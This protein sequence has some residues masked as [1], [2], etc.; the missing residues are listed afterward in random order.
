MILDKD[1]YFMRKA[2]QEAQNAYDENEVPIGAVVVYNDRIIAKGYNQVERLKDSTAHAEMIAL[3][4]AYEL[5]GAKYLNDATLYVTVEPC[6]MC[7]GALYW[8]KI[9][10]IVYGASDEKNGISKYF[11]IKNPK[12]D[13]QKAWPFHPKTQLSYGV[14]ASEC[15]HLMQDFFKQLR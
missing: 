8:S 15:L 4:A 2:L 7:T 5:L 3:T 9:G 13:K 14:L 1:E 10:R 12:V 6:M 11:D